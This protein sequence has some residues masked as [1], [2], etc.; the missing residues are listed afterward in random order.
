VQLS[1]RVMLL[2][3]RPTS[4]Y[5]DVPI[6]VARPRQ[7]ADPRLIALEASITEDFFANVIKTAA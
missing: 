3:D 1:D 2:H 6:P 7:Q 5:R 4:V